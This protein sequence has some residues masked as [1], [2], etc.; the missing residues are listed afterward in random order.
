MYSQTYICVHMCVCTVYNSTLSYINM[1]FTGVK[2][3]NI[4]SFICPKKTVH[5]KMKFFY[6]IESNIPELSETPCLS[7]M[8]SLDTLPPF[9]QCFPCAVFLA[10]RLKKSYII[11]C[12]TANGYVKMQ[13]V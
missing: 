10:A 5:T 9:T 8:L 11:V 1:C 6:Y 12:V 7:S 3:L 2:Q 4:L 13:P